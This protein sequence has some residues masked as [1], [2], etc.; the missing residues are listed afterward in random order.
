MTDLARIAR[1]WLLSSRQQLIRTSAIAS[2]Y[3]GLGYSRSIS[4]T[5]TARSGSTTAKQKI[6]EKRALKQGM[7]ALFN[8]SYL[9]P[10]TIVPP[11]I[12]R[13]PLSPLKFGQ[14]VW[15]LAQNRARALA[16]LLGVTFVSMQ[17]PNGGYGWP[18]LRTGKR[19]SVPAAKAL[20]ALMSEAV[21]SGDK[22]TLRRICTTELFQTLAGAIDSRPA[23]IRTEW[24]LVRYDNKLVY[25]RIADFRV[26]YQPSASAAGGMK[27]MK[28]AVVG[29]SS[30]QRLTRYDDRAGGA[31]VPGGERER[32]MLEHIVLQ[33]QINERTF[34][35]EPWK[36]WGNLPEMSFE[37]LLKDTAM[38][39]DAM[40]REARRRGR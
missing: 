13:F 23:G 38:Y 7:A 28:Q 27:L 16:S 17:K 39:D 26:V 30:V 24:E 25:P 11:P 33:A 21:A 40:T 4:A 36:I 35:T 20:H 12:W 5:A 6:A 8:P 37:M 34:E 9:L 29:L 14:M 22:D 32:H 31:K 18:R 19:A 15:L 3:L 10:Y 1:P 2:P